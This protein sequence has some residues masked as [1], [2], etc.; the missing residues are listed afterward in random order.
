MCRCQY[1]FDTHSKTTTLPNTLSDVAKT[2]LSSD[3]R[4]V[5]YGNMIVSYLD[6]AVTGIG[7]LTS[8]SI[9]NGTY[10]IT[11]PTMFVPRTIYE[12]F[13]GF[14]ESFNI[15]ADREFVL[16]LAA[17]GI[18]FVKL[19]QPLARFFLGGASSQT[20]LRF[21]LE[22]SLDEFKIARRYYPLI[23]AIKITWAMFFRLF[24][25]AALSWFISD[26]EFLLRKVERVKG[27]DL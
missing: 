20:S 10:Q 3:R 14:D 1:L 5:I 23:T 2:F 24:R 18:K 26:H 27:R 16:R 17:A 21:A 9:E 12:E 8:E 11:H 15:G 6:S 22:Q 25:N 13:G 7:D 4:S 19:E